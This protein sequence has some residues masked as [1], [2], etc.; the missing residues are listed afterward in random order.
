MGRSEHKALGREARL[1]RRLY[2]G[3][4]CVCGV[5]IV[6]GVIQTFNQASVERD[7]ED[8]RREHEKQEAQADAQIANLW[9]TNAQLFGS[10]IWERRQAGAY[11]AK[12]IKT[13]RQVNDL[14]EDVDRLRSNW[15]SE[16]GIEP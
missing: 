7:L 6:F 11:E 15:T 8:A 3:M 10:L 5:L 16:L 14:R 9:A 13:Q 4:L 1:Y 2:R 12:G